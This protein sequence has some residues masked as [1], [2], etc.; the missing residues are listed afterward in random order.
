M[1]VFWF[2]GLF[3]SKTLYLDLSSPL[4]F[5]PFCMWP[6]VVS[7]CVHTKCIS[8]TP[9]QNTRTHKP[10]ASGKGVYCPQRERGRA[11]ER[12][13]E[14]TLIVVCSPPPPKQHKER[15][16]RALL[17]SRQ[18]WPIRKRFQTRRQRVLHHGTATPT[19]TKTKARPRRDIEYPLVGMELIKYALVIGCT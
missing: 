13:S 4:G 1:F 7:G 5:H 11:R 2:F 9:P 8:T 17:V 16:S 15:T 6:K 10:P 12:G 14:P 18:W 3:V 19:T